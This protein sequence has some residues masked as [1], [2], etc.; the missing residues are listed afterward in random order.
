MM[1]TQKRWGLLV[2][3]GLLLGGGMAVGAPAPA[4]AQLCA[5]V[6]V[7]TPSTAP[8]VGHCEPLL[9]EWIDPCYSVTPMVVGY[10]AR[11]AA[12]APTPV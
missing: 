12:C 8:H 9:E 5:E 1:R 3:A 7:Y 2:A 10:G 6:T 4:G 11:V